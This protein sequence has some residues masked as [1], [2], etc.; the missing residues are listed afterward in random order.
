[1][2]NPMIEEPAPY[3]AAVAVAFAA[4]D[5]TALTASQAN[6]LPVTFPAGG[7]PAA[8][9]L[10]ALAAQRWQ[11]GT[12]LNATGYGSVRVQVDGISG[13]D[14]IGFTCS[15]A[16]GGTAYPWQAHDQAGNAYA[17]ISAPGIYLL[18]GRG[19]ITPV[20]AGSASSPVLTVAANQ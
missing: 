4:P 3:V 6:P 16:A 1:M 8:V 17:A 15:L 14:S 10:A 20:Q 13:G 5:G 18:A 2:T 9:S 12:A 19:I 7:A 11:V